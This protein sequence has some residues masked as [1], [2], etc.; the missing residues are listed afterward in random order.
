MLKRLLFIFYFLSCSIVVNAQFTVNV[1]PSGVS[2]CPLEEL[3]LKAVVTGSGP[4]TYRWYV[5]TNPGVTIGT[6][7]EIV[8]T[9][10]GLVAGLNYVHVEVAYAGDT[11]DNF[12][13]IGLKSS[14]EYELVD[15]T[16][17]CSGD[18][19]RLQGRTNTANVSY[20]WNTNVP[21]PIP[22]DNDKPF[23]LANKP[24][25]YWV[26]VNP[27]PATIVCP[28]ADTV[29][30]RQSNLG[31]QLSVSNDAP[32]EGENV[33]ITN[34]ANTSAGASYEW[35]T[36]ETGSE[37]TVNTSGIY[38]LEVSD[39][40]QP[41]CISAEEVRLNFIEKPIIEL[42]P[43]K[44]ICRK[45]S[46]VIENTL[47]N[48]NPNL[49]YE[50]KYFGN[51]NITL[52]SRPKVK[53]NVPGKYRLKI[54]TGNSICSAVDSIAIDR[55]AI[56]VDLPND[57]AFC[58][59]E[60]YNLSPINSLPNNIIYTWN[61]GSSS[62]SIEVNSSGKY[63]LT[64]SSP[65][66]PGC[67]ETDSVTIVFYDQITFD[68]DS[69]VVS[70]T[71]F[72]VINGAQRISPKPGSLYNY[73]WQNNQNSLISTDSIV[74]ITESGFHRLTVIN[75]ALNCTGVFEFE[76]RLKKADLPLVKVFIPNAFSPSA[77]VDDSRVFKIFSQGLIEDN[78]S[79]KVY[80]QWG[81]L[82]YENENLQDLQNTGWDGETANGLLINGSYVYTVNAITNTGAPYKTTGT[83]T[84]VR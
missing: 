7:S 77:T 10:Q 33:I 28:T 53:T 50:W 1:S 22:Q 3:T 8:I 81:Q 76:V 29:I 39:P 83:V 67:T 14:M 44:T 42:G 12:G 45:D 34:V 24:G 20:R 70:D 63:F 51:G 35:N 52:P 23:Y 40:S 6:E 9:S 46:V 57:T 72:A 4:Y 73:Q 32:C 62:P 61:T 79:L 66:L 58:D 18:T 82:M 2:K 80:N 47:P 41:D 49:T 54:N 15:D 71:N 65:T 74:E 21:N 17:I 78:F 55:L 75:P 36:G 59:R 26:R 60:K 5:R 64:V 69:P 56:N 48:S 38:R 31:V 68:L 25:K 30:I 19:V 27:P 84:F 11:V 13:F 43:N 16:T 37:I